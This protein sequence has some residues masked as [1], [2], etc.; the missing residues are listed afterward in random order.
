MTI[1]EP[2]EGTIISRTSPLDNNIAAR[3]M[4]RISTQGISDVIEMS[5]MSPP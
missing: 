1:L 3:D 4:T 5:G 2:V